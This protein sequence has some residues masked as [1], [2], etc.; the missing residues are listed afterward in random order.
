MRHAGNEQKLLRSILEQGIR[1]PLLGTCREGH[2]ILLDGFK[3]LRCAKKLAIHQL[4]FRVI[5]DDEGQG[6]IVLM[7][8]ANAQNL[9]ILEQA[10]LIDELR[11]THGISVSEIAQRLER[12]IGW[13]SMRSGLL[14][15]MRAPVVEK[16]LKGDFPA[17]SYMY[18]LR[19]FMRMNKVQPA[20]IEAFVFATAG[21]GLSTR[22]IDVL[23]SGY[24]RGGEEIRREIAAGNIDWSLTALNRVEGGSSSCSDD[25]TKVIA[26]LEIISRKMRRLIAPGGDSRLSSSGFF[27]QAHLLC[28]GILRF[29]QPFT[30][31][32]RGLHDRCRPKKEH[33]SSS[34]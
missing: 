20:E 33:C 31:R 21:R 18:T 6:I 25:E 4:P 27:A 11:K 32:M 26:D 8:R 14:T 34:Q 13:V 29:I 1:D 17:Y 2:A 5:G 10:R 19:H 22:D 9:T 28:G 12:S 30:E 23:A 3:R 15:E 16:I 7:R 24:F